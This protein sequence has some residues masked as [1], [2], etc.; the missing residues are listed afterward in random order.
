[1]E[2]QVHGALHQLPATFSTAT[3]KMSLAVTKKRIIKNIYIWWRNWAE[4]G[5]LMASYITAWPGVEEE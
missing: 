5:L 3:S 1:M 2:R 4:D